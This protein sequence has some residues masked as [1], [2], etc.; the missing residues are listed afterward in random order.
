MGSPNAEK[1]VTCYLNGHLKHYCD[2]TADRGGRAVGVDEDEVEGER[3]ARGA[4]GG[5][6]RERGKE[7]SRRSRTS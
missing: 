4:R 6:E 1:S 7:I 5:E 2:V 3:V